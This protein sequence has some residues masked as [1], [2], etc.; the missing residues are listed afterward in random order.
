MSQFPEEVQLVF[1][2]LTN[3]NIGADIMFHNHNK[4]TNISIPKNLIVN[5]RHWVGVML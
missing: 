1:K 5:N 3:C 4:L 2:M